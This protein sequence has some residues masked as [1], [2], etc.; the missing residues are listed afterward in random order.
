MS[1]VQ[2]AITPYEK[3]YL[4]KYFGMK[5][6][7][8]RR[9]ASKDATQA[10]LRNGATGCHGEALT[11]VEGKPLKVVP[12]ELDRLDQEGRIYWPEKEGGWP[13][14]KQYLDETKGR[15]SVDLG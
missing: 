10:G 14:L 15:N 4:D 8:G 13:R 3:A 12:T 2:R 11:R 6:A 1:D 7:D 9:F 5:D